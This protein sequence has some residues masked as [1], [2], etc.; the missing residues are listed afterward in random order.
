MFQDQQ[1]NL[2]G[3][4]VV[5]TGG[6]TGI[7]REIAVQLTS[8]NCNVIIAGR[9]EDHLQETL[10]AI[11][12]T[13]PEGMCNG[14][15]ADLATPEGIARLFEEVDSLFGSQLD[16]LINNAALAYGSVSEGGYNDWNEVVNTNL[17]S[18]IACANEAIKRMEPY[19]N[20]HV[21]NIGSMSADTKEEGSSI[22]VATKAGIQGFSESLRKEVNEKGINITLIEPGAVDTDMQPQDTQEKSE[23]VEKDEMLKAADIAT[24]VIYSL[25][26][27]KR[28]D[29][30]EI[31]LRP[32]L[33]LI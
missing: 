6:T 22:Y 18:Y 24:A 3:R 26:Q 2:N 9:S 16:V 32:R 30:V 29:V 13:N 8:L 31:R 11:K 17:L 4:R 20:G 7:G 19:Q 5:I 21:I 15:L 33:Q 12:N 10:N 14:V 23:A 1:S 27:D 25:S 28:C